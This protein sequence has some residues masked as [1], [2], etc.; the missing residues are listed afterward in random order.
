[1]RLTPRFPRKPWESMEIHDF[2]QNL[3]IFRKLN[4]KSCIVT[5]SEY[6]W[7]NLD[8]NLIHPP[9]CLQAYSTSSPKPARE[10]SSQVPSPCDMSPMPRRTQ[11]HNV[12]S[13]DEALT[14]LSFASPKVLS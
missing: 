1:M 7:G 9:S 14:Y 5:L 8:A 4:E 10:Q 6:F 2:L 11:L 12:I 13:D 3:S